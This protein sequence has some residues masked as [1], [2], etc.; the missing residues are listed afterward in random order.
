MKLFKV[1]ALASVAA[2]SASPAAFGYD[3]YE[4][5]FQWYCESDEATKEQKQTVDA[6]YEA[7]SMDKEHSACKDAMDVLS[8]YTHLEMPGKGLTDLA[9]LTGLKL[10]DTL[11]IKGNSLANLDTLPE[12]PELKSL[13]VSSNKLTAQPDFS[14]YP[15]ITDLA[16]SHNAIASIDTAAISKVQFL[17]VQG[18]PLTDLS[19]LGKLNSLTTVELGGHS[20]ENIMA[21]L[22]KLSKLTGLVVAKQQLANLEFL[23]KTPKLRTLGLNGTGIKDLSALKSLRSLR[24]LDLRDNAITSIP[25][26]VLARSFENLALGSNPISDFGFLKQV[27][28]VSGVFSL[29]GLEALRWNHIAHIVPTVRTN[30]DLSDSHIPS[31]DLPGSRN[32]EWQMRNLHLKGTKITS[33]APFKRITIPMLR[34]F[35]G[36]KMASKNEENCPTEGVP[37]GVASF[38]METDED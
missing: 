8:S 10:L 4:K 26:G 1:A 12:L 35:T 5:D 38:C 24:D 23:S 2:I 34:A 28:R 3:Q 33:L 20:D 9:P 6:I 32:Y 11:N 27:R 37:G 13:D 25:S 29:T 36:P 22:P 21:T 31:I 18:L 30:L 14:K 16:L 7:I 15:K 17:Y 19:F